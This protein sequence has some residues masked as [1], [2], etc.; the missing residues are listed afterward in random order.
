LCYCLS[1]A[2]G[3]GSA[4]FGCVPLSVTTNP[5]LTDV[6]VLLAKEA[7]DLIALRRQGSIEVANTKSSTVDIVTAVDQ[8]SEAL[9]FSRL[10]ELRPGDGFLGEEGKAREST[11]GITWVVD[12]IDGTVNFFYDIPHYAVS[13]AAVSGPPVPGQWSVEAGAVYNPATKELFWAG[14]GQG[15]YLG[16]RRLQI[17]TP[18]PLGRTL[19]ATGFSYS[20]AMRKEQSRLMHQILPQIRDIRRMGTA[21]L[22]LA[23]VAAGRVDIFFERTLNPWDHAAGE[24]LV[25]EAGG[26]IRG[27]AGQPAGREGL[28]AG[29]QELVEQLQSLVSKL[30]GDTLLQDIPGW[31]LE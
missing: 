5:S 11:T 27:I 12:P 26:V 16:E 25:T 15:A 10:S 20:S 23:A 21:S 1:W 19:L 31:G 22:D 9:V 3:R 28:Y 7:G 8:E 18:P 14:K 17:A 2:Q 29:H 24:L 13:I 6:A 30:D 4:Y